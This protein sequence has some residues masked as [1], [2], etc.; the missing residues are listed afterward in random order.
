MSPGTL[1]LDIGFNGHLILTT[2]LLTTEP[3]GI[4]D[5]F[6]VVKLLITG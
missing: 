2:V 1:M 3:Y 5:L 4:G 6:H